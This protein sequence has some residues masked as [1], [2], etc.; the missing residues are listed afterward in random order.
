[1]R[2]SRRPPRVQARVRINVVV[3]SLPRAGTLDRSWHARALIAESLA[4]QEGRGKD[5]LVASPIRRFPGRSRPSAVEP[6]VARIHARSRR[7]GCHAE[8]AGHYRLSGPS[9]ITPRPDAPSTS[10][11]AGRSSR[12]CRMA[13]SSAVS[14]ARCRSNQAQSIEPCSRPPWTAKNAIP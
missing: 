8:A 4:K 6:D 11:C 7:H 10:T 3:G 12:R 5:G 1:M 9:R 14:T 2:V 13:P